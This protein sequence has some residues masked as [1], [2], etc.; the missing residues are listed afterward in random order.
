MK[1]T[2][3]YCTPRVTDFTVSHLASGKLSRKA[4]PTSKSNE[5]YQNYVCSCLLRIARKVQARLPVSQVVVHAVAELLNRAT[6]LLENRVIL[7]VAIP[8]AT[9]ERLNFTAIDPYDSMSN[10]NH[11]INFTRTGGF[12]P[13]D[14]V[15]IAAPIPYPKRS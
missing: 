9:L 4:L 13:V 3:Q 14:R 12:K 6:G 10:F 7:S 5:I 15:S 2:E 1:E 8:R 11:S